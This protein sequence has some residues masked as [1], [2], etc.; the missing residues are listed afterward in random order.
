[1]PNIIKPYIYFFLVRLNMCMVVYILYLLNRRFSMTQVPLLG[2]VIWLVLLVFEIPTG[3][4]AG[5]SG[6]KHRCSV[7]ALSLPWV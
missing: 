7:P 3:N 4:V 5:R 2:S 6:K 1:V